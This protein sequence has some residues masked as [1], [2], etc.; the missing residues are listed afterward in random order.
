MA[1]VC[2][3]PAASSGAADEGVRRTVAEMLEQIERRGEAA[4]REYSRRLDGW[5]PPAFRIAADE[6]AA[7]AAE[8]PRSPSARSR[9]S[10]PPSGR[11]STSSSTRRCPA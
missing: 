5:D 4:I 10:R 8:V 9:A 1:E 11:R 2:K 3:A 7:S 6:L